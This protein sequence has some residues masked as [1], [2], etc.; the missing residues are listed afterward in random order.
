MRSLFNTALLKEQLKRYWPIGVITFLAYFLGCLMPIWNN[1]GSKYPSPDEMIQLLEMQNPIIIISNIITPLVAVISIFSYMYRQ[2]STGAIHSLPFTKKQLFASNVM[3]GY[4][5]T[6]LPLV[7]FSLLLLAVPVEFRLDYAYS[8]NPY[9][10]TRWIAI[11]IFPNGLTYGE[12]VNTLPVVTGFFARTLLSFTF[13]YVLFITAAMMVG[14]HIVYFL[15]SAVLPFIAAGFCALFGVTAFFYLFGYGIERVLIEKTLTFTNPILMSTG[16]TYAESSEPYINKIDGMG[17]YYIAYVVIIAA[18]LVLSYGMHRA[19][20][21][22]RAGDTVVFAPLKNFFIFM[23]SLSG[24]VLMGVFLM[25]MLDSVAFLYVGFVIGFIIAFIIAQMIAEKSFNVFYKYKAGVAFW[26]LKALMRH[27]AVAVALLAAVVIT[28]K[29]DLTG[30]VRYMPEASEV[31]GVYFGWSG[32]LKSYDPASEAY[33]KQ[34]ISDPRIIGETLAA[35]GQVINARA[36]QRKAFL[37]SIS[38]SYD[39]QEH[40][41]WEYQPIIYRLKNGKIVTREYRLS[42]AF[43]DEY[44]SDI[45]YSETVILS[46]LFWLEISECLNQIALRPYIYTQ[47]NGEERINHN[48]KEIMIYKADEIRSLIE[49]LKKDYVKHK[50]NDSR[51]EEYDA[52]CFDAHTKTNECGGIWGSY[53]LD[54]GYGKNTLEWL[55]TH[56]YKVEKLD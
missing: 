47:Q 9:M 55:N 52:V 7:L 16:F 10:Y 45:I 44:F 13:Y 2:N 50:Q 15:V 19:R 25:A 12:V 24:M 48:Y 11:D 42:K 21:L 49:A 8:S 53:Y 14:N 43:H 37:N 6:I 31:A 33:E 38:S 56:G 17:G 26:Q 3:A 20:G 32:R 5:L 27:A 23:I 30:Y 18:L 51:V 46:D 40:I 1:A 36:E 22:E 28:C 54:I 39:R 4:L 29:M 35:H 41:S 34:F